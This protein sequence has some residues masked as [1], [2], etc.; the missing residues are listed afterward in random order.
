MAPQDVAKSKECHIL[1]CSIEYTGALPG[2]G[3]LVYFQP[4]P[5]SADKDNEIWAAQFRGRGLL[6]KPISTNGQVLLVKGNAFQCISTFDKVSEWQHTHQP[7]ALGSAPS[8]VSDVMDWYQIASA[9]HAPLQ[10][11][12]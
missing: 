9:L 3:R 2:D 11:D 4:Q 8:R 5:L 1:P 10:M 6:T 7:S 12:K